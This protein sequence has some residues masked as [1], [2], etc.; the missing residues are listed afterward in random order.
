MMIFVNYLSGGGKVVPDWMVHFSER[1]RGGSGMTFVDLVFPAF[2][3]VMGMSVPQAL[4]ARQARGESLGSILAHVVTRTL[5]LLLIGILMVHE[6]PDTAML[7]WP[8]SW[9]CVLMYLSCIVAFGSLSR[10]GKPNQWRFAQ[11]T[12][13]ITGLV[14]LVWLAFAFRGAKGER[15]I[16]LSPFAIST[17]WYGIL[18]L[19]GW[20]YLV[21]ATVFLVFRTNRTALLGC[22]ALL[23]CL[24]AAD[25]KGVF[26]G[27][28]LNRIV[29]IGAVLGSLSAISVGG[30]LLGSIL[31]DERMVKLSA[32]A[33]FTGW[34]IAGGV[35]A[36]L[37][38]DPLYGIGKNA[39]TPSWCFWACAITA[40]LW[41]GFYLVCDL[42]PVEAISRPLVWA[43]KNVLLAYLISEMI[44]SLLEALHLGGFYSL[45]GSSLSAAIL[46]SVACSV[47]I[48]LVSTGLNRL[49]FI[50]RL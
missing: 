31:M 17:E 32:R 6:T 20:A 4:G 39:A 28:W 10:S 33:T 47:I 21:T 45:L 12:L 27:F 29:G 43:G 3:F 36:A 48:L 9:W 7:G 14:A 50:L 16:S 41:Y 24:F 23:M 15:I 38:L 5:S 13:R 22:V 30:L 49:G 25:R 35:A 19:I 46:C 1:H 26:D 8:G 2:L 40:A 18:G 11:V 44:P 37:L 34:F 42:H